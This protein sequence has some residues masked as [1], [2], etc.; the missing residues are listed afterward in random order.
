MPMYNRGALLPFSSAPSAP[1]DGDSYYNTTDHKGYIYENGIWKQ[2][3]TGIETAPTA[4]T[5][6][7]RGTNQ[8]N[9]TIVFA[10]WWRNGRYLH[11]DFHFEFTG[12]VDSL[13]SP[14]Y[15]ELPVVNSS[16]LC[17]DTTNSYGGNSAISN[18]GRNH[19]GH[20][21][22]FQAGTGWKIIHACAEDSSG[23]NFYRV[24][25]AENPGYVTMNYLSYS[26]Q[27]S[28]IKCNHFRCPI[29]GWS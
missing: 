5:P 6:V 19:F 28:S 21:T 1:A 29:V 26:G 23:G 9:V 25:F 10:N 8:A 20:A 18:A 4:F 2:I 22:W 16:Q 12:Q 13:V 24:R 11:L 14:W 17:L 15:F 7:Y 27:N 3:K